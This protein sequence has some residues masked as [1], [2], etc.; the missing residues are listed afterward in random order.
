LLR[1]NRSASLACAA[2]LSRYASS[3]MSLN[4]LYEEHTRKVTVAFDLTAQD[5]D[6]DV[7]SK[8]SSPKCCVK[9]TFR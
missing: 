7:V 1:R 6:P 5:L 3:G 2:K 8:G 4:P 9:A